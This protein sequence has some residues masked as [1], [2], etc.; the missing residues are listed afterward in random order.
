M[1]NLG[2]NNARQLIDKAVAAGAD[3][4]Q[5]ESLLNNNPKLMSML[6]GMSPDAAA[7]F[8]TLLSDP[9]RAKQLLNSPQ[10]RQLLGSLGLGRK[11]GK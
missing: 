7:R 9:A 11:Q 2:N 3:R 5:L 8:S 6:S 10:A 4:A 1:N